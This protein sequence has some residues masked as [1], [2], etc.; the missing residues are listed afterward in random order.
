MVVFGTLVQPTTTDTNSSQ[1]ISIV[2]VNNALLSLEE[3]NKRLRLSYKE[4]KKYM[5]DKEKEWEKYLDFTKQHYENRIKQF[6]QI[7][8]EELLRQI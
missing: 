7:D 2:E 3:E 1:N 5:E 4:H 8:E 6:K